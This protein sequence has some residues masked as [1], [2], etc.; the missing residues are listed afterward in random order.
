M[1]EVQS[2][3]H[4]FVYKKFRVMLVILGILFCFQDFTHAADQ[5]PCVTALSEISDS[6]SHDWLE[7]MRREAEKA[8][9]ETQRLRQAVQTVG[10]SSVALN[11]D[12]LAKHNSQYT[13]EISRG[14]IT[15]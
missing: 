5:N 1:G 3:S 14:V 9:P 7:E 6:I 8:S 11:R 12:V 13:K 2:K 4:R 10:A 15:D